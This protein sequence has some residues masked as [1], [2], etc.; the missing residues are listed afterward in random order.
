MNACSGARV[1]AAETQCHPRNS[2]AERRAVFNH[3]NSLFRSLLILF[4]FFGVVR[5]SILHRVETSWVISLF[6]ILSSYSQISFTIF[7]L[8]E[9]RIVICFFFFFSF[10]CFEVK[11]CNLCYS[12]ARLDVAILKKVSIVSCCSWRLQCL[13]MKILS[14][15]Q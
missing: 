6:R 5:K 7:H 11:H 8:E 1:L 15:I 4:F 12:V 14:Q 2:D 3:F 10:F 13:S 9:I